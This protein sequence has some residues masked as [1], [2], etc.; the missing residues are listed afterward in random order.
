[1]EDAGDITGFNNAETV[2]VFK[3]FTAQTKPPRLPDMGLQSLNPSI[4]FYLTP[5][6]LMI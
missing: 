2:L 1:L 6:N 3:V 5:Q 4:K